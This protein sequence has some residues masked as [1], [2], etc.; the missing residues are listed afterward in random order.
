MSQSDTWRWADDKGEQRLVDAEELRT[1]IANGVL[2]PSTLVWREGMTAWVP[3]ISI[4]EFADVA[5]TGDQSVHP[6]PPAADANKSAAPGRSTLQGL[7]AKDVRASVAAEK[8]TPSVAPPRLVPSGAKPP[9]T[10]KTLRPNTGPAVP[11]APRLRSDL[12][13]K[14]PAAPRP[15]LGTVQTTAPTP[16]P[17]P[18]PPVRAP[19]ST[20]D[21][22]ITDDETTNVP[23]KAASTEPRPEPPAETTSRQIP[24]ASRQNTARAFPPPHT[25]LEGGPSQETTESATFQFSKNTLSNL[26]AGKPQP[27]AESEKPAGVEAGPPPS[28]MDAY[29]KHPS[30]TR[31]SPIADDLPPTAPSP[32]LESALD[33]DGLPAYA[34]K[35]AKLSDYLPKPPPIRESTA[36]TMLPEDMDDAEA[37]QR[38]RPH[39]VSRTIRLAGDFLAKVLSPASAGRPPRLDTSNNAG[40]LNG[41]MQIKPPPL[42][43]PTSGLKPDGTQ[44]PQ[45][46]RLPSAAPHAATSLALRQV[47]ESAQKP[48][49]P[50][51]T[52]AQTQLPLNAL[53][54][55]GGLLI[56]MVI[57]AFFVGRCSVKPDASNTGMA[58]AGLTNALQVSKAKAPPPAK[59]CSVSRQSARWAPAVSKSLPFD[60][61][62]LPSGKIAIGFAEDSN[63]AV[64]IEVNPTTGQVDKKFAD[65]TNSDIERVT[66]TG[67]VFFI[68]TTE[69]SDTLRQVVPVAGEKPFY[70][71]MANASLT[72]AEKLDSR[73]SSLWSLEGDLSLDSARVISTTGGGYLVSLRRKAGIYAGVLGADH[74]PLGELVQVAGSGGSVGKPMSGSNNREVAITFA[75][76]TNDQ[77]PWKIRVGRAPIGKIPQTTTMVEVP[78]GG[79]GGDAEAPAIVGLS[80]GRWVLVWTE[81]SSGSRAVRAQTFGSNFAPTGPAL[82]VST[83]SGNFGRSV[84]GVV[85]NLVTVVFLQKSRSNYE[86]WG[87]VLQCG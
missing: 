74:K 54:M 47:Q 48:P 67:K 25:L 13:G 79:P 16:A 53:L 19:I 56:T 37:A 39:E 27:L 36:T 52:P 50:A 72:W 26:K 66:P 17:A 85:G 76:R 35:T 2:S 49:T 64:G 30:A 77:S 9:T 6:K 84:I 15:G 29:A 23:T 55:T 81:G 62:A 4:A 46:V 57:G 45:F 22:S 51:Q 33:E 82:A 41:L 69:T 7:H 5:P 32:N 40:F 24:V 42:P 8:R 12:A 34:N 10:A 59:P 18:A 65:K 71:G 83:P 14:P 31:P 1:A 68:S 11:A 61:L 58:K 80:D 73:P 43:P 44:Q 60:L 86:L 28:L 21:W 38:R 75:D 20:K 87:S 3:A 70:L 78:A 63:K